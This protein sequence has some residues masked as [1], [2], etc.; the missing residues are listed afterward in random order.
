MK[1][2]NIRSISISTIATDSDILADQV[3]LLTSGITSIKKANAQH[4]QTKKKQQVA[5]GRSSV[6]KS[7][8]DAIFSFVCE[9]FSEEFL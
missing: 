6:K 8:Q 1:A 9:R 3:S 2:K 7:A 5:E 4:L